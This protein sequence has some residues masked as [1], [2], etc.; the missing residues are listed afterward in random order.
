MIRACLVAP[1][2]ALLAMLPLLSNAQERL[3]TSPITHLNAEKGWLTLN[4]DG[5][6]FTV[7]ASPAARP[8]INKLPHAGT[9]EVFVEMRANDLPLLKRWK[10][11]S[12]ESTCKVFDGKSC[13]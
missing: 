10:L 7:E 6:I 5:R 4:A 8:H 3:I 1:A 13:R 9:I 12:G 11:L 2:F